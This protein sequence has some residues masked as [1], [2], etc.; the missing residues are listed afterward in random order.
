M[1]LTKIT[2]GFGISICSIRDFF[3]HFSGESK[4]VLVRY[5]ELDQ[6]FVPVRSFFPHLHSVSLI[7]VSLTRDNPEEFWKNRG[8]EP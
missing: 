8:Y 2:Q 1:F 4:L 6:F 5:F 7:R 3:V